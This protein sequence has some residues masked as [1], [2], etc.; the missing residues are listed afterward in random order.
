MLK[1]ENG[2]I[3]SEIGRAENPDAILTGPAREVAGCYSSAFHSL[4][5]AKQRQLQR[6]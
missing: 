1:T 5:R 6:R 4:L 2:A 3:H